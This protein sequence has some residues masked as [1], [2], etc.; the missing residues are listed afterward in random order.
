MER[1]IKS[2]IAK[3]HLGLLVAM[4]AATNISIKSIIN[5]NISQPYSRGIIMS[6][7]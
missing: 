3:P 6:T 7:L 2:M 1:H 5:P 4:V